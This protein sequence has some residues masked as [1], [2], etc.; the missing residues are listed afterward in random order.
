MN[1]EIILFDEVTADL[2]QETVREVLDVIKGLI[3]QGLTIIVVTHKMEFAEKAA[4]KIIFMEKGKIIE[5]NTPDKFS[6]ST[7]T[8]EVRRLLNLSDGFVSIVQSAI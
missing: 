7:S 5:T 8:V 6:S 4:D 1:P 3:D 2:D